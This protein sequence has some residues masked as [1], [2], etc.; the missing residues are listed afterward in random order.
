MANSPDSSTTL[1][2]AE[3]VQARMSEKRLFEARFLFHKFSSTIEPQVSLRLEQSLEEKITRAGKYF[4]HGRRMEELQRYEEAE[5]D[6]G[7]VLAI[8]V[9]YPSIDQA[10]QR[11]VVL[12]KLGP[13]Q[14]PSIPD[15]GGEPSEHAVSVE[16]Q[17]TEVPGRPNLRRRWKILVLSLFLVFVGSAALLLTG[18]GFLGSGSSEP[19]SRK[20]VTSGSMPVVQ[21]ATNTLAVMPVTSPGHNEQVEKMKGIV[22]PRVISPPIINAVTASPV[23]A[24]SVVKNTQ[25]K[26]LPAEQLAVEEQSVIKAVIPLQGPVIKVPANNDAPSFAVAESSEIAQ[27]TVAKEKKET[28]A[29]ATVRDDHS[30]S[31]TIKVQIYIVQAGDTLEAIAGK[32]YG[33]RSQWSSLAQA[34]REQLGRPP[35]VLAVGEKIVI[36]PREEAAKMHSVSP[37]AMDGT[38]TVVSGDSLGVIARKVYGSSRRWQRLY[39]LNRDRLSSPSALRVGQKLR[40]RKEMDASVDSDPVGE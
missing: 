16:M 8:A 6:Y 14:A 18:R 36:P 2:S 13:L 19:P 31:S 7:C 5:K 3:L 29:A 25:N 39:D 23:K 34:N 4:K 9:D 24:G 30:S 33:D 17:G 1:A 37:D 20:N 12:R 38:Y 15:D 35:Y 22:L 10:L 32:V 40:T 11:I 27:K 26:K 21:L 28:G